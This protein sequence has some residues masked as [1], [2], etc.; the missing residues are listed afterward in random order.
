MFIAMTR[1]MR[2]QPRQEAAHFLGIVRNRDAAIQALANPPQP[3]Q[4]GNYALEYDLRV[5]LRINALGVIEART[6]THLVVQLRAWT[7]PASR[8]AGE[9]PELLESFVYARPKANSNMRTYLRDAMRAALI[10]ASLQGWAGDLRDLRLNPRQT[11][12]T[13]F[14]DDPEVVASRNATL[15]IDTAV[16]NPPTSSRLTNPETG[17]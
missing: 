16:S 1:L 4:W 5:A 12:S 13:G 8:D 3:A 15:E 14:W 2:V 10:R 11:D 6:R 17:Q 7:S 9:P